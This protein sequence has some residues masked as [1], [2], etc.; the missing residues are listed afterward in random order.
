MFRR[1]GRLRLCWLALV[2]FIAASTGSAAFAATKDDLSP[3]ER[4]RFEHG[5]DL[6]GASAAGRK[7]DGQDRDGH[8]RLERASQSSPTIG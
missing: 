5:P 2:L 8:G 3:D 4:Q 7:C 1:I 6:W